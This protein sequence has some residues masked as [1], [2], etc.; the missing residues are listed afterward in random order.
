[1]ITGASY[2]D[3]SSRYPLQEAQSRKGMRK[4]SHDDSRTSPPEQ[5]RIQVTVVCKTLEPLELSQYT[6][7]IVY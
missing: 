5:A 3:G 4:Y 2:V 7:Q 1:L 6:E